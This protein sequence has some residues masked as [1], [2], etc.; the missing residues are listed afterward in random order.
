[1]IAREARI[2]PKVSVWIGDAIA[3]ALDDQ[4]DHSGRCPPATASPAYEREMVA[5]RGADDVDD[6]VGDGEILAAAI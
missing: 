1:M 3:T 5:A 4:R 6:A 2:T